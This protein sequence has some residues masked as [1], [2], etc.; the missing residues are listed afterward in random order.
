LSIL[1]GWW[2]EGCIE[3]LTGWA[4][5]Q[6]H[7]AESSDKGNA[8]SLYDKLE[9]TVIPMFYRNQGSWVNIMRHTIAIN[10]S[11][12]NTHRMVLQYALNAYLD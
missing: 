9:H 5:G 4:I 3:D 7:E 10:G 2:I 1:D 8:D 6:I 12:F 11:F